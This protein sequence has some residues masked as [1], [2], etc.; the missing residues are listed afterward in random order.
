M[1]EQREI[2]LS[3]RSCS[4]HLELQI[5]MKL[6]KPHEHTRAQKHVIDQL[7]NLDVFVCCTVVPLFVVDILLPYGISAVLRVSL[8]LR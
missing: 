1:E 5:I 6:T 8:T 4:D 3:R 7:V 2:S